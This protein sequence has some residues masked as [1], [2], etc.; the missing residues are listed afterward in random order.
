VSNE[1]T[2]WFTRGRTG[3]FIHWGLYALAARHEWVKNY[4]RMGD[5]DYRRYFDRF[6]P[7]LY[8]PAAW[9]RLAR[10]AG[11][12]YVV[13]TTK[14]HDGF[15]L[16]DSACTD[17]K[18]TNTPWGRDVLRP[19]VEAFRAEGL[20]VGF[21]YSL[22]DWHHP[23]FPIDEMHPQR[24][25]AAARRA[26]AGRRMPEYAR[27][28][29]EQVR[30][31]LTG[32]GRIDLLWFDFT[33]PGPDGKGPGDWES[34]KL[35]ELVRSL[36]PDI[37]LN[38]RLGLPETADFFTPEQHQPHAPPR[39]ARGRPVVWEGCH[40]LSGS[41]GYH[42]DEDTWKSPH[43]LLSILVDGVAKGGNL[44]LNVG[45]TARGEFDPR[46]C[47]R[48][49][50]MAR[51]MHAHERSVRGCGPAPSGWVPPP[52][53]RYTWNAATRRLYLHF[54]RWPFKHVHLPGLG[55]EVEYA[56][57]LNDAS[58]VRIRNASKEIHPSLD[59]PTPEGALTIELPVRQPPAEIPVV[60]LFLKSA[61]G[62]RK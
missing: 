37:L 26:A 40:T 3:L 15:C 18:A 56:Q 30:E 19:M 10:R 5:G 58:E 6:E 36:Q 47:D 17:Y 1:R 53:T 4:E 51:W 32:F 44:L 7:D 14:H 62:G 48:L 28:M 25:D 52:D 33:Y 55:D 27:Y 60:E 38:N 57:L 21:Y 20:R 24:D 34:E 61:G 50:A 8:D 12:E 39:D 54:L 23:E 43:Q 29:R 46:A 45:P 35:V 16:W 31:L 42:R 22:L 11:M 13:I 59:D 2:A 49:E 41:W 9:A